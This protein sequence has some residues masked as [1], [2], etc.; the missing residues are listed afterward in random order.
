M[1]TYKKK[2]KIKIER[3]NV[4]H[5][6]FKRSGIYRFIGINFIKLVITTLIL[7]TIFFFVEKYLID[8]NS[9]FDYLF[10]NLNST[11]VFL[12]FFISEIFLGLLPP[13]LFIAWTNSCYSPWVGVS[14]LA[15]SSYFASYF[16]YKI[17]TYIRSIPKVNR[18]IEKKYEKNYVLVKKFGGLVIVFAALFPLPYS[19]VI[20]I[21]GI[22][23]FPLKTLM[24][25]AIFRIIRF[26]IFA[27]FI[28]WGLNS[29]I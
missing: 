20:L 6:Y 5:N 19:P 26:Y 4:Y 16:S 27:T 11:I 15:F 12:V 10:K 1:V 17:G 21:S 8:F 25:L 2:A 9:I 22:L 14:I 23:K 18:I 7:A 24:L 29:Q 3:I 28:F 13:D